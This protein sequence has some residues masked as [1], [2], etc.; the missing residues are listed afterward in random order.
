MNIRVINSEMS[1]EIRKMYDC[2][3]SVWKISDKTGIPGQT[4]H[5]HLVRIGFKLRSKSESIRRH[6]L[7]HNI[8]ENIDSHE[9]AYWLGMLFADGSMT[10]NKGIHTVSLTLHR[11]DRYQIESFK[12]FLGSTVKIHDR[13]DKLASSLVVSGKEFCEHLKNK[14][15]IPR[16]SLILQAPKG[17]PDQFINSFVLGVFDGDGCIHI[18]E[19]KRYLTKQVHIRIVGSYDFMFFLN[20]KISEMTGIPLRRLKKA[21]NSGIYSISYDGRIITGNLLSWM[22][23]DSSVYLKRKHKLYVDFS[24][25][26]KTEENRKSKIKRIVQKEIDGTIVREW[27]SVREASETLG[28][29]SSNIYSCLSGHIKKSYGFKWEYIL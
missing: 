16:K 18:R 13:K 12:S 22:Y 2:G 4:I 15:M 29:T 9:K 3:L 23:R 11:E 1:T 26:N 14:G 7:N 24:L 17:V 25:N 21:H 5:K 20:E 8:F 10:F 19:M 28:V 6:S 27:D